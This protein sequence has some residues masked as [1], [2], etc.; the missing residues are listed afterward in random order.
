LRLYKTPNLSKVE[1]K[2]KKKK[3]KRFVVLANKQSVHTQR[4]FFLKNKINNPHLV[5]Y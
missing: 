3:K 4:G 1:K 2:K 5:N